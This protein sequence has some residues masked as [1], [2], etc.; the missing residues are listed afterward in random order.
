M[1]EQKPQIGSPEINPEFFVRVN[2]ILEQANRVE[3]RLD[4][5]HAQLVI[6]HAFCRYS[7]HHFRQV[8]KPGDDS[9]E[10]RGRFADYM[11]AHVRES[12]LKHLD[13]LA[14]APQAQAAAQEEKD[15]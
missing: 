2:D 11:S 7:A 3:Q 8:V 12:I 10:E 9:A 4:S 14:G 1:T 15:A 5:S 6:L 13:D